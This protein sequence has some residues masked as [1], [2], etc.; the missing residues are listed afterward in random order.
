[1][2]IHAEA[3]HVPVLRADADRLGGSAHDLSFRDAL[4]GAAR[5]P[6]EPFAGLKA[7]DTGPQVTRLQKILI[8]WNSNLG[9]SCT[10]RYDEATSRAM[11]L[12]QA[13]YGRGGDGRA[14]EPQV[15]TYLRQ[16][17]DGSF[18]RNPPPKTPAQAMLYHASRKLGVPY[19]MGGDGQ[20]ATDCG[21]L[22]GMALRQSGVHG[23]ASRLAD[24]QFRAAER[25]VAGLSLAARPAPGDLVFFRVPTRQSGE[26][27]RGITHVGLYVGNGMMLAASS[28]AGRVIL[29]PVSDLGAYVAGYGRPPGA[30]AGL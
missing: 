15:A 24:S 12:F 27:Y 22:T 21:M 7:G 28:S 20:T 5:P 14:V 1:M 26:A 8:K 3:A 23:A 17:E 9:V 30:M 6:V 25:G 11:T 10:G 19:R 29:Q 2:L 16:M 13:I 4:L 18:W